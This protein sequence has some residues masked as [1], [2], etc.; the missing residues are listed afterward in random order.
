M[1]QEVHRGCRQE[2]I[3]DIY[4]VCVAEDVYHDVNIDFAWKIWKL[5][6]FVPGLRTIKLEWTACNDIL[7]NYSFQVLWTRHDCPKGVKWPLP[8]AAAAVFLM[9]WNIPVPSN[10]L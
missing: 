3:N 2:A 1:L 9:G 5:L 8:D 4:S 6:C 10:S 7:Y